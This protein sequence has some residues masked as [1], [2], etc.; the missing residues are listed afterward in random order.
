MP[1]SSRPLALPSG[2]TLRPMNRPGVSC[3]SAFTTRGQESAL[4]NTREYLIASLP[5]PIEKPPRCPAPE[6]DCPWQSLSSNAMVE[7]YFSILPLLKEHDASS[8]CLPSHCN[9]LQTSYKQRLAML[10]HTTSGIVRF[11]TSPYYR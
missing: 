3:S 8:D 4:P 10:R 11:C 9:P 1:S 5:A 6:L 7:R 2:S